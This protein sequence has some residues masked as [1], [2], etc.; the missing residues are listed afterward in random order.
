MAGLIIFLVVLLIV[1]I[2]G[3]LIITKFEL[4]RTALMIFGVFLLLALLLFLFGGLPGV[5]GPNWR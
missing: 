3:Y 1:G 5:P 2:A 4:G